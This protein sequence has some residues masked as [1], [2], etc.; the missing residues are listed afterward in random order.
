[1]EFYA[2][3]CG[4]CQNFAPTWRNFSRSVK[5]WAPVV[6][7]AAIDCGSTANTLIC[8]NHSIRGFP[9]IK[10]F[11]AQADLE[12][13]PPQILSA[14][15]V[16]TLQDAVLAHMRNETTL[17][18]ARPLAA[19]AEWLPAAKGSAPAVVLACATDNSRLCG[20][21]R[22]ALSS[23]SSSA[24]ARVFLATGSAAP[25]QLP[26]AVLPAVLLVHA[27][28][29]MTEIP[30]PEFRQPLIDQLTSHLAGAQNHQAVVAITTTSSPPPPPPPPVAA[31]VRE[32]APMPKNQL[33]AQQ[34]QQKQQ[35]EAAPAST[36]PGALQLYS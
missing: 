2:S 8:R 1:V 21:L 6:Q 13:R 9:T 10:F 30:Q 14:R 36:S 3:W 23:S 33:L 19:A 29:T 26:V 7:V 32:Q 22:L 25:P 20:S 18:D 5:P 17:L 11:P 16:D 35:H 4:H 28:G 24:A 27:D 31:V 34:Q 12:Q 15:T